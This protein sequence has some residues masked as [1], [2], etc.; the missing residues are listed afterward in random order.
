LAVLPFRTADDGDVEGLGLVAIEAMGCGLPVI[1]GDVPAIHDV[2]THGETGWIVPSDAPDA[3]ATAI[4]ELLDNEALAA[5]LR[6]NARRHALQSFD[7]SV[8][9]QLYRDILLE[10]SD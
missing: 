9:T 8:V 3:L 10:L 4:I 6:D 7:W 2:V 1:V 5:R